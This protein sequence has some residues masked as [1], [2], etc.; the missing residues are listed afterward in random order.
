MYVIGLD[1]CW[2]RGKYQAPLIGTIGVP[3][4]DD[5]TEKQSEPGKHGEIRC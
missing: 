1:G 4:L 2:D 3:N 5:F